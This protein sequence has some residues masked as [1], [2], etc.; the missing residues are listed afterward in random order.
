MTESVFVTPQ[1]AAVWRGVRE[2][3]P[4]GG[5]WQPW[6]L[7][8]ARIATAFSDDMDLLARTP[9]GVRASLR[10]DASGLALP[11][12][13]PAGPDEPDRRLD[14]LVD[15]EL[16]ERVDLSPG[17]Q[18]VEV[19]LAR[20]DKQ[21]DVW[22]PQTGPVQVG[23]L[24]LT[25]AA[26]PTVAPALDRRPRWITYGSSI[27]QASAADG[28]SLTWPALV[29]RANGWDLTCLGFGGN[30][31]LD[32]LVARTIAATPAELVSMCLGI[33]IYGGATFSPRTFGP[34]VC[35]FVEQVRAAH[36]GVPLAV[37]T[38]I[39]SP[40]RETTPNAVDLTLVQMRQIL[41]EVVETLVDLGD[42]DLHLVDGLA[43]LA[44]Q[45][46]DRLPDDLHPD[47]EGYRL[48]AERL[49]PVLAQLPR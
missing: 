20:G 22:L 4:A 37:I 42:A 48:M 10:T 19:G 5:W 34:H 13:V 45:D 24:E 11:V 40:G 39:Y 46:A 16:V 15:D 14:V 43:V 44:E 29:A 9:A 32:P 41:A 49:A 1:T 3:V 18:R 33:N 47:T 17:E 2:W 7:P 35:G 23:A 31:H 8:A 28:P 26:T 25:G 6:R 36:P 30:C 12:V 38:P 27:T 21:V